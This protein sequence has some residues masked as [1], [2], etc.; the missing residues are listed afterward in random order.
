MA[1]NEKE[2]FELESAINILSHEQQRAEQGIGYCKGKSALKKA[3]DLVII[4]LNREVPKALIPNKRIRGLGK[5]PS[6]KVELCDFDKDG[7]CSDCG[8]AIKGDGNE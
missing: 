5:C 4:A 8:Q 1:M 7:Y 3:I 6:C 2:R